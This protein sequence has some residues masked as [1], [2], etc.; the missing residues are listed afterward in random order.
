[1]TTSLTG[2]NAF[3]S[4]VTGINLNYT[5]GIITNLTGAT[6]FIGTLSGNILI[7][8]TGSFSSL[9]S[10]S[11]LTTSL[12]G[13][14]ANIANLTGINLNYTNGIISNLT[15]V[16]ASFTNLTGTNFNIANITGVNL[17]YTN[18]IITNLTGATGFI[19][20]LSGNVLIY[21]TGSFGS[22]TA[23]SILTTS[24]TGTNAFIS[25]ITGINLNYT[26]GVITNF[27][28]ATGFIGTLT[29]N[30]LIYGT[31]SF[32]SLT[33]NSLLTTSLTGTNANIANLTGI[34]LNYTNGIISN[35]TGVNA[36]FTNLT[37][38]NFNIANIT[39]INLNYTNGIITNLTGT[40]GF[41]GTLSGN[42]LIYGTGTINSLT[43]NSILTTSFTGTNANITNLT[44]TNLNYTNGIITNLTGVN[45]VITNITGTNIT[46]T[47]G[48]FNNVQAQVAGTGI[49]GLMTS[50]NYI[51]TT[52]MYDAQADFGFVGDLRSV[53]D[54]AMTGGLS[55]L[56]C[57][58]SQPFIPTHVGK[59]VTVARAGAAGAQL[60][61]TVATYVSSSTVT[62]TVAATT[63]VTGAGTQV[64]TDNTTA[65][66]LM[67]NTVNSNIWGSRIYFGL[68]PTN[69]YGF[70]ITINFYKQVQIEGIG[71]SFSEDSGDYTQVGGTRLAYWGTSSDGGVPFDSFIFIGP[72]GTSSQTLKGV[73]LRRLWIDCRNGD[74]NSALMGIQLQGCYGPILEDVFIMDALAYGLQCLPATGTTDN[75]GVIRALLSHVNGRML[76][77]QGVTTTPTTT[78]SA[79]LLSNT[80]TQSLTLAAAT[81]GTTAFP[82]GY[83][84]VMNICGYPSLVHYTGGG[85]TTTL[86]GCIVSPCQAVNA[87]TTIS[88]S[89]VVGC[90]PQNGCFMNFDGNSGAN[91]NASIIMNCAA[92]YGT[93]WGPAAVECINSDSNDMIDCFFNGGNP[94]VINA[95]NRVTKPGVRLNGSAT[96]L[97]L[98]CRNWTFR[99][100]DM[101]SLNG[102]GISIMGV[103]ATGAILLSPA[104]SNYCELYQL[105]NGDALPTAETGT[106]FQWTGNGLFPP[107]PISSPSTGSQLLVV[108]TKTLIIG[109]FVTV[110]SNGFQIGTTLQWTIH[111]SKTAAGTAA[112][113]VA[114]SYGSTGTAAGDIVEIASFSITPSAIIDTGVMEITLTVIGP[115]GAACNAVCTYSLIHVQLGQTFTAAAGTNG[116]IGLGANYGT[117]TM[118]TFN[119]ALPSTSNAFL[120]V[121]ITAGTAEALTIIAP[122]Y[123]TCIKS[124]NP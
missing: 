53:F 13:T 47:Q 101:G 119:S 86:T 120:H 65:A 116:A 24:L 8:G 115:L 52:S 56:V 74:Q 93:T 77:T 17:N 11:L 114:I 91:F 37:G 106:S 48:V 111:M 5:N 83:C 57:A 61:T 21:G 34:N 19:G 82:S 109:T 104:T 2:T 67:M 81:V 59:R 46:Y 121:D 122:T 70:P 25:N 29:G 84:W 94:T 97:T 90:C 60:T 92:S 51:R 102:G 26:N 31:G 15:G 28:G 76:E 4:N 6:G 108:G 7:Y 96:N 43:S 103:G 72:T 78:T 118:T 85:G 42:V 99:G 38:T 69:A 66:T 55:T 27:T 54:G 41:I 14:N 98:S 18:G 44:G 1:M 80:T 49:T 22:L 35:L 95:I 39:G 75:G 68:S 107:G 87:P 58:T 12:T 64:G 112:R 32:S 89:N 50:A 9:T 30:V 10:N 110:P 45:A 113:T 117:A 62:T 40:T 100:G 88:G 3:I 23:N 36:S 124:A 20:T 63:S 105:G 33:S 79:V 123:A 71:G 73:A 16:N